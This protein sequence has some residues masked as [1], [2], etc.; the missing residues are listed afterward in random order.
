[1]GPSPTPTVTPVPTEPSLRLAA[2]IGTD[3][4]ARLSNPA[5]NAVLRRIVYLE[6][7]YDS[8]GFP[9]WGCTGTFI[10]PDA[11]L[12]SGHCL[13]DPV[14]GWVSGVA[15]APGRDGSSLPYGYEYAANWWVPNGWINSGGTT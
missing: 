9:L 15:V 14:F 1:M 6:E 5:A 4:R 10:G 2:V 7:M 3:D 11:V 8:L 12:T 13:Y